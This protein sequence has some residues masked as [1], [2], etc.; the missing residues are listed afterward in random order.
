MDGRAAAVASGVDA[1][2]GIEGVP[3]AQGQLRMAAATRR[4]P[5]EPDLLMPGPVLVTGIGDS[6]ARFE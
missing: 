1:G 2:V 4:S 6:R 5:T 3:D